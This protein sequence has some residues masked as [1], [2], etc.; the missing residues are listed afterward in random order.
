M[1]VGTKSILCGVHQFI[2]H[3][4]TVLFAWIELYG[5]PNWKE[6]VCIIIHDLGYWSSPN[7][8]GVE[9]EQHPVYAAQMAYKYLDYHTGSKT[10]HLTDDCWKYYDLCLYHSRSC[11]K[12]FGVSPSKLCWADKLSIKYDPWWFYLPR[13]W[14]SG[15]LY[16]YRSD[17]ARFG[18]VPLTAT[19]REWFT[20]AKKRG[21]HVGLSENP[22]PAY[23][24]EVS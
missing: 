3:P 16:E 4:I 2:W 14:L 1:K 10:P 7:I 18:F 24:G 22:A 8:D 20:W 21:I 9:G 17:A 19:H 6:F 15:E 5:F 23:E 13:A 11:A 12:K